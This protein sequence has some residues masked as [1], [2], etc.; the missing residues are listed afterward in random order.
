MHGMR[1]S[2]HVA[3]IGPSA[4]GNFAMA[5]TSAWL[6]LQ[7]MAPSVG[8]HNAECTALNAATSEQLHS[9]LHT[10]PGQ[11]VGGLMHALFVRIDA[12]LGIRGTSPSCLQREQMYSDEP[13]QSLHS[14]QIL[15]PLL[16]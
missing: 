7:R 16:P 8:P 10:A 4:A 6:K 11:R 2:C 14:S 12:L 5:C 9:A 3:G 1:I 15:L 13:S